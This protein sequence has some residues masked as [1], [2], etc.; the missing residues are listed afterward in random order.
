MTLPSSPRPGGVAPAERERVVEL[1]SRHFA[2]DAITMEELEARLDRVYAAATPA[3]LSAVVADLPTLAEPEAPGTA[4][5]APV[6]R[7]TATLSGQEQ[8]VTGVVP[9]RVELKSRLGYIEID[10]TRATFAPGVTE[11]DVRAFMGYVQLRLPAGVRVECLGKAMLGFFSLGGAAATES[12]SA[13]SVVRITGKATCGFAECMVVRRD[14][15]QL[16]GGER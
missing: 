11:I 14:A 13:A 8:R 7:V 1:L 9:R 15:Q 3:E 12:Q 5:S 10:F 2:D 4:V 6:Q 16:P